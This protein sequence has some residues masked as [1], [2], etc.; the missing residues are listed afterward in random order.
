[1]GKD[2]QLSEKRESF[3]PQTFCRIQYLIHV[4][5]WLLMAQGRVYTHTC[6]VDIFKKISHKPLG[7]S[8]IIGDYR[9][10]WG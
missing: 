8:T 3:P 1:M 9:I 4:S 2:L 5:D 7:Y 6:M 10:K